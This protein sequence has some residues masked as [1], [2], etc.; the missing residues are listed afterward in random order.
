[1]NSICW[2]NGNFLK[3]GNTRI[4]L[5]DIAITRGYGVFDFFKVRSGHPLFMERHLQRFIASAEYMRIPVEQNERDL[6]GIVEELIRVNGL[7]NGGIRLLLTGGN[8]GDGYSIGHPNLIVSTH[9]LL[10]QPVEKLDTGMA[11]LT[12]AYR[13]PFGKIKTINYEMGVWM[14]HLVKAQGFDD[15]L[16]TENGQ[17]FECPRANIFMVSREGKLVTPQENVLEGITRGNVIRL[18]KEKM[19]MEIRDLSENELY[20]AQEIFVTSTSKSVFPVSRINNHM[21]GD[22]KPGKITR[23]FRAL[24]Q[25]LEEDLISQQQ[26]GQSGA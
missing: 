21:I 12:C 19:E 6:A 9:V 17:V 11:L 23:E 20:S 26:S 24:L 5:E 25:Q 2:I 7:D 22:G 4:A 14:Q 18:A 3:T 8:G 16:Y 15:C 1:M 10:P 13:R